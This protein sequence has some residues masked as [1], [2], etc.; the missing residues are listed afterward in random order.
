MNLDSD[1][2]TLFCCIMDFGK[3]SKALKLAKRLG[4]IGRT[5]FL[6]RGT[7]RNEILNILGLSEIRK[8]IFLT[9]IDEELEEVFYDEMSNKFHLDK[10][11]QGIAF[12]M[13]LKSAIKIGKNRSLKNLI[14]MEESKDLSDINSKGVTN[15]DYEAIFIIV[16]KGLSDSVLDAASS[17]GSTG[18]TGIHGRGSGTR[19]KEKIFNIEIE[20]G[21]DIILILSEVEKAKAIVKAIKVE[22]EILKPGAGII[23]VLDVNN[24]LG[25]YEE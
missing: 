20:P 5:I 10:P 4:S 12:S 8:E 11:N 17:A 19:E 21:K 14:E 9:M 6:G 1:K 3:G 16:D 18:G 7:V 15:V 13:P 25:L 24:T 2:L 23:F 22:L